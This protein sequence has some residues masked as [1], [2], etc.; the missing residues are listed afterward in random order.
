MTLDQLKPGSEGRIK[1]LSVRDKLGQRLMDMGVYPGLK[2]K[3]IRN[4]PLEDPMELELDGYF[5]SLR[6]DEA[7]FVEVE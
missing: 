3:V 1:K 2:L 7:R 5:V 4:A 6:H